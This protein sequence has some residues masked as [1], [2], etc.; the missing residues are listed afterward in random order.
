MRILVADD[1]P[2]YQ[3]LLQAYLSE[4][5]HEVTLVEDGAK[6]W[7][8]LSSDYPPLLALVDWMMPEMD[9]ME[10]VRRIRGKKDTPYIYLILLTAKDQH[11]DLVE[12]FSVGVDDFLKKPVEPEELRAR[13]NVGVRVVEYELA[14]AESNSQLEVYASE[15]EKLA[16]ERAKQLVHADRMATLGLL[17]AG[18]AHEI[19]NPATFISGNLQMMKSVWPILE[20]IIKGQLEQG[21]AE[22]AGKLEFIQKEMPGVIQGMENGVRR[23]AGITS[24]LKSYARQKKQ[25]AH[26]CNLNL[27]VE[28]ALD[29]CRNALKY[30]VEVHKELADELPV[31]M[32]DT[33]QI[34]QVLVN[35]FM[36]AAHAVEERGGGDLF[37]TTRLQNSAVQVIVEDTGTG[38]PPEKLDRIWDP[39]FTTKPV[40][41]GTGLGLSIVKGIVEDHKGTIIAENRKDGGTRFTLSFPVSGGH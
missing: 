5:G 25:E 2:T 32:A 18:L 21:D 28:A 17:T 16:E 15:M 26:P 23:I 1:D 40:G 33:Q 22:N 12:A 39:F 27:R 35:L 4:W 31:V 20:N 9:G 24:G 8:Y 34:E 29:L 14:L 38:I 30:Q 41:K 37:V 3:T 13:L 36:N 10:V 19:N 6:A 7:E 11:E